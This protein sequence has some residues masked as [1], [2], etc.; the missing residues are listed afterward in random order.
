M[1]SIMRFDRWEDSMGALVLE[2]SAPRGI[3]TTTAG[4][5]NNKGYI[6][7]TGNFQ[8]A[9]GATSEVTPSIMTFNATAGRLYR[10]TVNGNANGSAS[11]GEWG[12]VMG[13]VN[14]TQV[15]QAV[16]NQNNLNGSSNI[17]SSFFFTGNGSTTVK[18]NY[19]SIGGTTQLG[20][21]STQPLYITLEDIGP[22]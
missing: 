17:S 5:T 4:G 19:Q 2:G 22:A 8:I 3:V 9:S 14:G 15:H 1:A 18:I 6:K 20:A 12:V 11:S 7:Y 16:I 13:Y 10:Y 21:T